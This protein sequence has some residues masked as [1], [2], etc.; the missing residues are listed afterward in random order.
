MVRIKNILSA[1]VIIPALIILT[2]LCGIQHLSQT[3]VKTP[4]ILL[5][6]EDE[7]AYQPDY[8]VYIVDSADILTDDEESELLDVMW[9]GTAYGNMVFLTIDS[10][11]G[12]NSSDYIE[13]LY[14]TSSELAGTDAVIYII[15]MDNR[16]L[17]ISGYGAL[18]SVI[19]PDYGNLITDNVYTYARNGD[20]GST[21]I[22]GYEQ[23]V[24]KLDGE[25]VSG[26]L[27]TLGNGCIALICGV[28]LTFFFAFV[29]SISR[30]ADDDDILEMLDRRLRFTNGRVTKTRTERIYDPPKSSGGGGGSRGGGGGGFHGGGGGHGF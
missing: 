17:W 8:Q 22:R 20:Y 9:N 26:P 24:R 19:T 13:R 11:D 1:G 14:Q 3:D 4:G 15:D 2:V 25:S 28:V 10:A 18:K 12:Y 27:R 16:M 5:S 6:A 21:A 30:K 29:T 23:I 7:T